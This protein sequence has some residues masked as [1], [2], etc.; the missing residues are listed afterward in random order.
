[1]RLGT[2]CHFFAQV[3]MCCWIMSSFYDFCCIRCASQCM[4]LLKWS[5]LLFY[6]SLCPVPFKLFWFILFYLI[7][8][9]Y[10]WFHYWLLFDSYIN[11]AFAQCLYHLSCF[12]YFASFVEVKYLTIG[13]HLPPFSPF[14]VRAQN[15]RYF[16]FLSKMYCHRHSQL[17]QFPINVLQSWQLAI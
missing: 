9:C 2:K 5:Y 3:S 16:Y 1:M 6:Y 8:S 15:Q 13:V 10:Y 4:L 7:P 11:W 14:L 12:Y 17:H